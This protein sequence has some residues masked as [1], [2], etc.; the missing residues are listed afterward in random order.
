MYSYITEV[1]LDGWLSAIIFGVIFTIAI[2]ITNEKRE[3][4]SAKSSLKFELM[5]NLNYL[6]YIYWQNEHPEE[7]PRDIHFAN[8]NLFSSYAG[9]MIK[10]YPEIGSILITLYSAFD[11]VLKTKQIISTYEDAHDLFFYAKTINDK[12]KLGLDNNQIE[13][14]LHLDYSI[15]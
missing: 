5:Q 13:R 15:R 7:F 4:K 2:N 10:N 8:I 6:A 11:E 3:L 1:A 9:I 12:L 14:M